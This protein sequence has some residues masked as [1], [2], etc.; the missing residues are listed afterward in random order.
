VVIAEGFSHEGRR[1]NNEDSFLIAENFAIVADGMGGHSK[2]EVASGMAVGSIKKC[3]DSS[4]E[5]T[6]NKIINA[7][8]K[9]NKEIF[10]KATED[11]SMSDMGTTV[12]MCSWNGD[13]AIVAN[14][15]DSR[16][17]HCYG[18]T[19]KQITTD[20]SYVQSL[21]DS[22]KITAKEAEERT[23]KNIILRAVGCEEDVEVDIFNIDVNKDDLLILCSDGLSGAVPD[24]DIRKIA[25]ENKNVKKAAELLVN[26]ANKNGGTD[27]ITVV[28]IKFE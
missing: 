3:L 13:K 2:G 23:D 21:I 15:G 20:H 26:E 1:K 24:E 5:I 4:S 27:N 9:A 11:H 22:G 19:I 17:Y 14:V 12:V 28:I 7:I 16:C 6:E 10:K 8:E 25:Q 18:K